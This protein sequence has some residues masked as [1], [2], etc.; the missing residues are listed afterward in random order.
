MASLLA[1][2]E[3]R[4]ARVVLPGVGHGVEASRQAVAAAIAIAVIAGTRVA[5]AREIIRPCRAGTPAHDAAAKALDALDADIRKLGPASDPAPLMKRLQALGDQQ[6]F[7]IVGGLSADAKSGLALRTWWEDGG[8]AVAAGALELGGKDPIV[9]VA[10]DVRRALTRETAA[11]HRLVPLLCPAYDESCGRDT[12]GW[13]LRAE[14][15]LERAARARHAQGEGFR[16]TLADW[17]R[18]RPPTD[19]DCPAYARKAPGRRKLASFQECLDATAGR[20]PTFPIGRVKK[21]LAGWLVVSGRRGHYAFCDELRAFD[22]ATGSTYRVA[23]CSGLALMSGGAVDHRATDGARKPDRE[24]GLV[25]LDEIREAAWMLLQLGELDKDV[26]THGFGQAP[27]EDLPLEREDNEERT[28]GIGM[29]SIS[30]SSGQTQLTWRV[31]A[32]GR[33]L[34]GGTIT[35]PRDLNDDAEAYATE[36]LDVAEHSFMPG[37]PPA[38]PPA[39][40]VAQL[41]NLSANRLDTD[42][43]SLNTAA[44]SLDGSWRALLGER[45]TGN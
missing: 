19:D 21:P 5:A 36:L 34:G 30:M 26:R 3:L 2:L 32:A 45:C 17:K 16:Q 44:T 9:W 42:T 7:R 28:F 43:N 27:P 18:E 10:P 40:L 41:A 37:C 20:S 22:L 12:D 31:T 24:R 4:P 33:E 35:W 11:D 23:S 1:R 38:A 29:G 8:H 6:C 13:R 14:A 39:A 25:S 15:A